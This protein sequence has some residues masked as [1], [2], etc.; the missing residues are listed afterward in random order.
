M[1]RILS[2]LLF[3]ALI[4][5]SFCSFTERSFAEEIETPVLE[6]DIDENWEVHHLEPVYTYIDNSQHKIDWYI[7]FINDLGE[8]M[9]NGVID[10]TSYASHMV[11][12]YSYTGQNYHSGTRHYFQYGGT[13]SKCGGFITYWMDAFCP[14]N[15]NC[16]LPWASPDLP[17]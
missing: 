15:G 4:S 5:A 8:Y 12:N 16:I 13:C 2:V 1:K 17:A 9:M 14:G 7:V 11:S 3:A 10:Q 6:D